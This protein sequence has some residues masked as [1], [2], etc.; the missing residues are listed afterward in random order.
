M[1]FDNQGDAAFFGGP[2]TGLDA[3]D[4]PLDSLVY[5]HLR[6]GLA[7]KGTTI[8]STQFSGRSNHGDLTIDLPADWG[9]NGR[10][11]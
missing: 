6:P 1:I 2:K 8:L 4:D 3:F 7:R 5:G 10:K 11:A 9:I